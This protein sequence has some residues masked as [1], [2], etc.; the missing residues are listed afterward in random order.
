[1]RETEKDR[2]RS[3]TKGERNKQERKRD[4]EILTEMEGSAWLIS[5]Y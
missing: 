3:E 5:T 4:K 2:E 1:M